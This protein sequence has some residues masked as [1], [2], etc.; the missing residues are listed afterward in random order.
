MQKST[1]TIWKCLLV[2]AAR[3]TSNAKA[4]AAARSWL[5]GCIGL[6]VWAMMSSLT[7]QAQDTA[8]NRKLFF[9]TQA[10]CTLTLTLNTKAL[11]QLTQPNQRLAATLQVEDSVQGSFTG[12]IE[13]GVRGKSR[14][15][16]CQPPPLMLYFLQ[17]SALGP[18]GN[19]KMVWNCKDGPPHDQLVVKEY[20]AYRLY[21]LLTPNSMR[22]RLVTV[23][24]HSADKPAKWHTRTGIILEDIDETA[25][26][27]NAKELNDTTLHAAA[28]QPEAYTLFCLFQYM[29]GN[30][31]WSVKGLQN[32]KLLQPKAK[33]LPPIPV[34]YD[35]DHSGLV[36][37]YYAA[38]HQSVP[39][40]EVWQ[41]YYK[42]IKRPWPQIQAGLQPFLQNKEVLLQE[43]A[44]NTHLATKEKKIVT[45]YLRDFFTLAA[46]AE[47]ARS[48]FC[49]E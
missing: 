21:N 48:I 19:L 23:R 4:Y 13:L 14:R 34:P 17:K 6:A 45:Q 18:K 47:R 37:A 46:D 3:V 20:L 36:S 9:A 10:P 7:L 42:G 26:R 39:V 41:R 38:P 11:E 30:T 8:L 29:I 49:S 43:V 27:L 2:P 25:K 40:E 32:V 44:T 33:H 35:F 1:Y 24:Y 5:M 16:F 15:E 28:L 22:A 12:P 31:D